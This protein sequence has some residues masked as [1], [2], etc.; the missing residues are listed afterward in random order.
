MP[1]PTHA[2][3]TARA[4]RRIQRIDGCPECVDNT[5]A[6]LSV[7]DLPTSYWSDGTPVPYFLAR[8][9][10]HSCGHR[11]ETAWADDGEDD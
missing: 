9:H 7:E 6:P 1:H 10:C 11:W 4:L 5:E 2:P 8:Y 3:L